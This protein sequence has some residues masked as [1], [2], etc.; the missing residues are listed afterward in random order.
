MKEGKEDEWEKKGGRKEG[1]KGGRKEGGRRGRWGQERDEGI[2]GKKKG[3]AEKKEKRM[4]HSSLAGQKS[5]S[6]V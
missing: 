4:E 2:E 3:R 6:H 1:K 5:K